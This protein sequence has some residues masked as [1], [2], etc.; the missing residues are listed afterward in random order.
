MSFEEKITVQIEDTDRAAA[1]FFA[2][3]FADKEI[4]NRAFV[5]A[6]CAN[7]VMKHL[8]T[9]G[10]D[11]RNLHNLH[12]VRKVLEEF[13]IADIELPNIHIDVRGVFDENEI[14]IPKTHFEFDILPDIYLIAK[15]N[16]ENSV[17]QEK[18]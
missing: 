2:C 5:N 15:F 4:K 8:V 17:E 18:E 10:A 7:L 16:E 11:V 3:K 1:S 13:D 9:L 6:L 14:F 12:Y